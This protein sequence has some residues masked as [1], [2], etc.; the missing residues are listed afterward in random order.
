MARGEAE[1]AGVDSSA[2]P[3]DPGNR[4]SAASSSD[5]EGAGW[6][7]ESGGVG[8][9][10]SGPASSAACAVIPALGPGMTVQPTAPTGGGA[11]GRGVETGGRGEGVQRERLASPEGPA[12]HRRLACKP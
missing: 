3:D 12:E 9:E 5:G 1:G 10:G 7:V 8:E 4:R 6:A 11:V 2:R